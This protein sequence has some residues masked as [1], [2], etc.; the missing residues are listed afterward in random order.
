MA[1]AE[2][3]YELIYWGGAPG[4][5]EFIRLLFEE[6]GVPYSDDGRAPSE[7]SKKVLGI[8]QGETDISFNPLPR[9]PPLLRHGDIVL[10]QTSNIMQYLAP[11]FGL[12]PSGGAAIYH[13]NEIVLTLMD[14]FVNELHDTHHAIAISLTYEEQQPESDRRA[15]YYLNDRLPKFLGYAQS[16]LNSKTSGQGPW[17]YGDNLTYADLVLF[18]VRNALPAISNSEHPN[19]KYSC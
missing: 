2:A 3:A 18:Q 4:R 8:L 5:G 10:S 17:L 13:L 14:G 6:A 15:K 19:P 9:A 11:K 16:I 1:Q 7:A 12:A